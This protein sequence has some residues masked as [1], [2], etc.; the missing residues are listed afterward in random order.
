M[1]CQTTCGPCVINFS[2]TH[3]LKKRWTDSLLK[4]PPALCPQ[5]PVC[6]PYRTKTCRVSYVQTLPLGA[7]KRFAGAGGGHVQ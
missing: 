7:G 6:G 3:C 1:S 2:F 4:T 5:L